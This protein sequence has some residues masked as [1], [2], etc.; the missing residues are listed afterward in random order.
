MAFGA[1]TILRRGVEVTRATLSNTPDGEKPK[2]PKISPWAALLVTLTI[3]GF[4]VLFFAI[5]YSYLNIVGTLTIIES[6]ETDAYVPVNTLPPSNDDDDDD[7]SHPKPPAS[8]PLL[9]PDLL[10]IKTKPITSSIRRTINHLR[11][12]YG[13]ASRFRGLALFLVWSLTHSLIVQFFGVPRF[14]NNWLGFALA[15]VIADVILARWELTWIH[16]VISEPTPG[17]SWWRRAPAFKDSW[18]KIAPAVA[19]RSVARQISAILPIVIGLSFGAFRRMRDPGFEPSRKELYMACGQSLFVFILAI[20]LAACVQLPATVILV[21]VAASMLPEENETV[22]PFDRSFGGKVTPAII[23]GQG[24]I[25]MLEAWKTFDWASRKRLLKL[26][27][28]VVA[29]FIALWVLVIFVVIAEAHL[30]VGAKNMRKI[31]GAIGEKM[32]QH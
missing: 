30:I 21:R 22:V 10:L 1:F 11:Y 16:I 25:G 28:K 32:D 12:N 29:I 17:R 5:Q 8:E 13:Y 6:P 24:K 4:A 9:E 2:M 20:I 14:M 3:L 19:L 7:D 23:G 31:I 15:S 27:G 26:I 18:V